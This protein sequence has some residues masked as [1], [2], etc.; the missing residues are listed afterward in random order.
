MLDG[1]RMTGIVSAD[2]C[3]VNGHGSTKGVDIRA[4]HQYNR[5]RWVRSLNGYSSKMRWQGSKQTAVLR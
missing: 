5:T 4:M 3:C 2:A 1:I